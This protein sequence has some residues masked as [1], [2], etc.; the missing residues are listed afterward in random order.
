MNVRGVPD[1]GQMASGPCK[2]SGSSPQTS[3]ALESKLAA[4][5]GGGREFVESEGVWCLTDRGVMKKRDPS[6]RTRCQSGIVL[7]SGGYPLKTLRGSD[8]RWGLG[9]GFQWIEIKDAQF[10]PPVV[11]IDR[12]V[13]IR[14]ANFWKK[15]SDVVRRVLSVQLKQDKSACVF[16]EKN[17]DSPV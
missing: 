12:S 17:M 8:P 6:P 9:V 3:R 11:V 2:P 13:T 5:V 10:A 4:F 7:T 1:D 14:I 15:V 16:V